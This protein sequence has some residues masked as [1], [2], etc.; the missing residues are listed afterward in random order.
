MTVNSGVLGRLC[1]AAISIDSVCQRRETKL[2]SLRGNRQRGGL[3]LH[4]L[5]CTEFSVYSMEADRHDDHSVS[6][7]ILVRRRLPTSVARD[8]PMTGAMQNS[9][10]S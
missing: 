5:C 10:G 9:G 4:K 7:A 2:G 1:A 6:G 3:I 8:L